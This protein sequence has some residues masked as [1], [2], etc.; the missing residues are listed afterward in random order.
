MI[1]YNLG[2][3]QLKAAP[4]YKESGKPI[5]VLTLPQSW[6]EPGL[7]RLEPVTPP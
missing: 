3:E 5:A 7:L 6:P 1:A 2:R 4:E